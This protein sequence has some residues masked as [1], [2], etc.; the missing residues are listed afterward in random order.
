M[1]TLRKHLTLAS[2]RHV[3][4]PVSGCI[5]LLVGFLGGFASSR[6]L[7]TVASDE[8][9]RAYLVNKGDAP[10]AVRMEVLSALRTFQEGYA[11]RDLAQLDTFMQRLFPESNEVLLLG[12]DATEWARGYRAI[13]EFVG[14]DWTYWGDLR[15]AVDD[16][17]IRTSGD[18]AWV[19]SAG[20]VRF[21]RLE[22]PVRFSAVLTRVRSGW[23][24]RQVHFQW[25]EKDASMRDLLRPE[26]YPRLLAGWAQSID[27]GFIGRPTRP[28]GNAP[29]VP[30]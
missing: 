21:S 15:F 14:A 3:V 12:T 29:G 28:A 17:V 13:R 18:V 19:A 24:F 1:L 20:T 5:L 22:R 16:S 23:L 8:V 10:A 11:R 30:R 27:F 7:K 6:H 9:R 26:V 2:S 4:L 25:D